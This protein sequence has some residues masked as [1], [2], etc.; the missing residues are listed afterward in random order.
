MTEFSNRL[1]RSAK[2]A[3]REAHVKAV[4]ETT[5]RP[6]R[7][8]I[9]V[10][11]SVRATVVAVLRELIPDMNAYEDAACDYTM[12]LKRWADEIEGG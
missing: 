7:G 11:A 12:R 9:I 6:F 3:E 5:G 2:D 10:D 4:L 8:S 1:L